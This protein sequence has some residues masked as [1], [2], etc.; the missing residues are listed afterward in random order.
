MNVITINVGQGGCNAAPLLIGYAGEDSMDAVDFDF[1]AWAHDYGEGTIS[2]ELMRTSDTAP[3]PAILTVDGTVARW[4]VSDVDTARSGPGVAQLVYKPTGATKKSAIYKFYVGR[5]ITEPGRDDPWGPIIE[6]M[7]EI[8]AEMQQ[9]AAAADQSAEDAEA[10]AVGERGGEPVPV[11]DETYENNAKYYAEQ[12]GETAR[13]FTEVTAPA[14]ARAVNEAGQAQAQAVNTAGAAAVQAVSAER[15]GALDAIGTARA[16]ALDAIDTASQTAV[17]DVDTAKTGAV[18][19]VNTAK[20]DAV[21]VIEQKST[22]EQEAVQQKG[23]DALAA[24]QEYA[25]LPGEVDNLK[26]AIDVVED[27]VGIISTITGTSFTIIPYEIKNGK[28]YT[29]NLTSGRIR[30]FSRLTENGEN[31]QYIIGDLTPSSAKSAPYT[32]DF[33]ATSDAHYLRVA[34]DSS[35]SFTLGLKNGLCNEVNELIP[36]VQNMQNQIGTKQQYTDITGYVSKPVNIK[37]GVKYYVKVTSGTLRLYTRATE[38]GENI[39]TIIGTSTTAPIETTF[40]ATANA[41]YLRIAADAS[42]TFYIIEYDGLE[43]LN[44]R[45][46]KNETDIQAVQEDIATAKEDIESAQ[47]DIDNI[48]GQLENVQSFSLPAAYASY[49]AVIEKDKTYIVRLTSGKTRIFTRATSDGTNI[50]FVIGDLTASSAKTA[51]YI[52]KFTATAN[53]SYLRVAADTTTTFTIEDCSTIKGKLN[54][55]D[56]DGVFGLFEYK[57]DIYSPY[58]QLPANTDPDSDFDADNTTAQDVYDYIDAIMAKYPQLLTKTVM[59]KDASN[60]Y[61]V[62]R[63]VYADSA[64]NS[65]FGTIYI[66]ANEHGPTSDPREC[67]IVVCRFLK[68]LCEGHAKT[69]RFL[70][71]IK[72]YFKV[73]CIP[74]ANPWGFNTNHRN[75]YNNVNIN[76]N[77]PT[78]PGWEN[79]PD[80]DKGSTPASEVETQYIVSTI[81]TFNPDIALDLHCLGYVTLAN[82][83]KCAYAGVV[84][85]QA[86]MDELVDVMKRDYDLTCTVYGVGD[87][88]THSD[89]DSYFAYK[90]IDGML[91]EF[92]ARDGTTGSSS[93]VLHSANIVEADYTFMLRILN[94]L[95]TVHN[96]DWDTRKV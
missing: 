40:T 95:M 87:Y 55:L 73:V 31:V 82:D 4:T 1:S 93:A 74:V 68:D 77:Y 19:A 27:A 57:P 65:Y 18:Q 47:E 52:T 62:N 79:C 90:G 80:A 20:T 10:W 26:S 94:I 13:E 25:D 39:D 49:P 46:S 37:S 35:F 63:Y 17:S 30:L 33:V 21:E 89:G 43:S 96:P 76:R 59:G 7:E 16:G 41:N 92:Q 45:V 54:L 36:P 69:N 72:K 70:N 34:S 23:E 50:D 28:T 61:D 38:N 81:E 22:E 88:M 48:K 78:V 15:A 44:I 85:N 58:P 32:M 60:T 12:A 11:T 53:A 64:R 91:L 86:M 14:A 9:Q 42:S 2:L 8:L 84:K 3:Y 29:V 6:R 5:S 24:L 75:N 67:A 51:P 56:Y 83:K 71:I 66:G